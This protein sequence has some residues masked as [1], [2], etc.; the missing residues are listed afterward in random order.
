MLLKKVKDGQM[1]YSSN[2]NAIYTKYSHFKNA[3]QQWSTDISYNCLIGVG[4]GI[5][6]MVEV[7]MLRHIFAQDVFEV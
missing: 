4:N 3:D 6:R 5:I 1:A 2:G 7:F